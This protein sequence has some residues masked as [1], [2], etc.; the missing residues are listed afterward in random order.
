MLLLL[1]FPHG[2]A[3][4]QLNK[5][6]Q[7]C[8]NEINKNFEKVTKAQAGDI[9]KC[10]KDAGKGKLTTSYSACLTSDP[11]GKVLKATGKLTSKVGDKC[12]G[13]DP[14][15]PPIDTS[16][17][18]FMN[19]RAKAKE[20]ALI[21]LLM[22]TDLDGAIVD[23]EV[24]K[25]GCKCQAA[26]TKQMFKCQ[27]AKLKSFNAC[28]KDQ[29]KGK[30]GPA[31][32][33]AQELQDACLGTGIEGIDDGKG[34]IA[35]DCA[36]KLTST[37][38]KCTDTGIFPGCGDVS[39]VDLA[40]CVDEIVECEVCLALNEIDGLRRDC[41]PFDD[42]LDNGSCP[43]CGNARVEF[44]EQCDDGNQTDEDGCS[45]VCL[46]E[47]CGD[48]VTQTA[49]GEECDDGNQLDG[50]GCS[51]SCVVEFC[52][53][54]IVQPT[55]DEHCDAPGS[56]CVNGSTCDPSCRCPGA[57]D[58]HIC[59]MDVDASCVGNDP[60][61]EPYVSQP[62]T[63][64]VLHSDCPPG[65]PAARCLQN[66][67]IVIHT[68]AFSPLITLPLSGRLDIDCAA[69]D[70]AT[71]KATCACE[72]ISVEGILIGGI[73]AVCISPGNDPCPAG[74]IDCDG[75][76]ALDTRVIH[77]HNVAPAA[78]L[79]DP[80]QFPVGFCGLIDLDN[81][82]DE[83]VEMCHAYCASLPGS[84]VRFNSGC[85]GFC[86]EG[87]RHGLPCEFD[88]ECPQGFCPGGDPVTEPHF[89][90]C[91]CLEVAGAASRTGALQCNIRA[92]LEIEIDLPCDGQDVTTTSIKPCV[93]LTTEFT[94][95]E[96]L[97]ANAGDPND[98]IGPLSDLGAPIS[99]AALTADNSAGLETVATISFID[100]GLGDL[101]VQFQIACQ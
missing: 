5:D 49:L 84:F 25:D 22:G 16:D 28:K 93:P 10:T 26:L 79:E 96:L 44:P 50:D 34:K 95:G 12:S 33:S 80:E 56:L 73:G 76:N 20:L 98:T 2:E 29:L 3:S 37:I 68:E 17:T 59:L 60:N 97:Q 78:N 74:E 85:E 77:N 39:A 72:L 88:S 53:D 69:I 15:F 66:S 40:K 36:A 30:S 63:D 86:S 101:V 87:S 8:V 58:T 14:A 61:S 31:V 6:A 65:P 51:S 43:V 47:E 21:R 89:C 54:G 67:H 48:G 52:G 100:T 4:A 11:K 42:G 1:A 90:N 45:S 83:C 24:D 82:H 13:G 18:A 81:G 99:C 32:T 75:G 70:P 94:M 55:L 23:C 19:E 64:T 9:S 62:C 7:K 38:G 35:K 71:G 91:S 46:S 92:G 41:D 27:S 57:I